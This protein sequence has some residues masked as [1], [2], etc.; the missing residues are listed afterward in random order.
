[1]TGKIDFKALCETIESY[2]GR[3]VG[4][5][6]HS[7]GDRDGVSSAV[8]LAEYFEDATVATPDFITRSAKRMLDDL[9]LKKRIST[10]IGNPDVMIILDTNTFESLGK[11]KEKALR[12]DEVLF[13]DHHTM[14]RNP[15]PRPTIFNDE[16]FNSTASIVC[17]LFDELGFGLDEN[18]AKL[19]LYGIAA[20]SADFKNATSLTFK[21][22]SSLLD[23]SRSDYSDI[24]LEMSSV[25]SSKIRY[26]Q[27]KDI[28]NS[29]LEVYG[30]YVI[31]CGETSLHAN[32]AAERALAMGADI[33]I[34]WAIRKEEISISGRMFPGL[35][36]KL[37]IHLGKIM[38]DAASFIDGNGGGHPCAAGAYGPKINGSAAAVSK[39]LSEIRERIK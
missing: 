19:L 21:Q 3:R 35:D 16:S 26:Q 23:I 27:I 24:L 25:S 6:F 4:I 15:N 10:S 18:M 17:R 1:M 38:Q 2:K 7:I 5:T 30:D 13:I 37:S 12:A 22:V 39:I 20:D 36:K 11:L 32:E 8:A 34:F 14:P 28:F 9:G 31:V 33:S 29:D